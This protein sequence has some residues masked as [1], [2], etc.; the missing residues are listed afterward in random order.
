MTEVSWI[1]QNPTALV[2]PLLIAAFEGEDDPARGG[3][4]ALAYMR[5]AFDAVRIAEVDVD[6]F[7]D[8]DS[9]RPFISTTDGIDRHIEWPKI[10]I[11]QGKDVSSNR[12]IILVHFLEPRVE[13]RS[14]CALVVDV[15]N[16]FNPNDTIFLGGQIVNAPHTSPSEVSVRS[17]SPRLMRSLGLMSDNFVGPTTMMGAAQ[18]ILDGK[19]ASVATMWSSVPHYLV[20]TPSPKAA[21]ALVA[22]IGELF[23]LALDASELDGAVSDYE[24]SITK[25]VE[26]DDEVFNYLARLG[27][28]ETDDDEADEDEF[29]AMD[30][31]AYASEMIDEAESYLRYI[32]R[33]TDR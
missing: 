29:A 15:I 31:T 10:E 12:D 8:Y 3:F 7:V 5:D 25:L 16:T 32:L 21:Q 22:K 1:R 9:T 24:D 4:M 23:H 11:Y 19:G 33:D 26:S 27:I 28:S 13:W 20:Q 17:N 30:P 2:N 18:I 14:Y 6:R